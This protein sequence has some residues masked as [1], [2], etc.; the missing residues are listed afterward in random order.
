MIQRP[1]I[2][3]ED[4]QPSLSSVVKMLHLQISNSESKP[5][6]L[7]DRDQNEGLRAGWWILPSAILGL[8]GWVG[9]FYGLGLL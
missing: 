1:R 8:A 5:T 4:E 2:R 6:A 3:R 7:R 9:I